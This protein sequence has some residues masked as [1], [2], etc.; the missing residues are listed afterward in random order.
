MRVIVTKVSACNVCPHRKEKWWYPFGLLNC[1]LAARWFDHK[2]TAL[3]VQPWCP[4]EKEG[5]KK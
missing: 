3:D 4:L 1:S 5:G 2:G